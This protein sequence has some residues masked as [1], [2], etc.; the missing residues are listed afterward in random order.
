MTEIK[1]GR[2][3][4]DVKLFVAMLALDH[5]NHCVTT[6]SLLDTQAAMIQAGIPHTPNVYFL[7]QDSNVPF[8]R[9][10]AVAQFMLTECT[11]LIFID[12]DITWD[13]KSLLRLICH[14]VDFVGG[15]YRKKIQNSLTG[16]LMT[17][18]AI[19][20]LYD[21]NGDTPGSDPETG[22][23]P[24][25]R[26]PAG[27]LRITRSAI[28]RMINECDVQE[29]EIDDHG[30]PLTIHRLFSFDHVGGSEVS[31]DY[32]FCDRWREIGGTVWCDPE[33]KIDHIGSATFAGHFGDFVR[34]LMQME[35]QAKTL[36]AAE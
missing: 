4:S 31:E 27:F 2:K 30:R 23:L 9:N 17:Q 20:G 3:A 7:M 13:T 26:L 16:E 10:R 35:Q 5:R 29:Y 19:D 24:V 11:D 12:S 15:T 14:P 25:K 32:R 8:A 1:S 21:E 28:Q 33:L 36:E 18:Y 22:L 6:A 34:T